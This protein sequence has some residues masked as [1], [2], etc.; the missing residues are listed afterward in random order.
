MSNNAIVSRLG[1][2]NGAGDAKALFLKVFG[3]EVLTSF[4]QKNVTMGRHQ[5]R[6]IANGKSA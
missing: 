4:E 3:G 1:Q 2:I 6:T 5:V